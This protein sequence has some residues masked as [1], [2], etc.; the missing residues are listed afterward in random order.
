MRTSFL[1]VNYPLFNFIVEMSLPIPKANPRLTGVTRLPHATRLRGAPRLTSD[2]IIK[3]YFEGFTSFL[4]ANDRNV[5]YAPKLD[6]T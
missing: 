4:T 3:F 6:L 2:V 5:T 1:F